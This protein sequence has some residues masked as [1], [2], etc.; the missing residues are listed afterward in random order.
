MHQLHEYQI[1]LGAKQRCLNPKKTG[2]ANYGGRGIRFLYKNFEEFYADL[3]PMPSPKH[4][5]ERKDNNADYA[6]GN[7]IWFTR[8]QQS[9]NRRTNVFVVFKGERMTLQQAATAAQ[10]NYSTLHKRIRSGW[11]A[12]E[13]LLYAAGALPDHRPAG[14]E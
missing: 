6:P 3:G 14:T 2:Y 8:K 5:I 9:N 4:T 10:L 1:Y 12:E 11:T 13:A 7:C